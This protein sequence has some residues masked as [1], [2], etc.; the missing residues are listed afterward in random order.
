[1]ISHSKLVPAKWCFYKKN[2]QQAQC[3][4]SPF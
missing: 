4:E 1:M 3:N 2:W